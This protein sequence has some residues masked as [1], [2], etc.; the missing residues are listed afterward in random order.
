M[1]ESSAC[2]G[3]LPESLSRTGFWGLPAVILNQVWIFINF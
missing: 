1:K 3:E 2:I